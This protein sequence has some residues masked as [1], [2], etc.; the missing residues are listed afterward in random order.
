[1]EVTRIFLGHAWRA[2]HPPDAAIPVDVPREERQESTQIK[3]IRFRAARPPIDLNARRI[4]D[5]VAHPL[6]Q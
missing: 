6:R 2:H 1:M 5:V 3:T 4:D